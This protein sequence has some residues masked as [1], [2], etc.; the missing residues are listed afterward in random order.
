MAEET[1]QTREPRQRQRSSGAR[2]SAPRSSASRASAVRVARGRWIGVRASAAVVLVAAVIGLLFFLRPTTS[3][4]EKRTLKEFPPFTLS[5]FLSGEWTSEVAL[6]YS[7]TYPLREPMVAVSQAIDTLHGV[8]PKTQLIGSGTVADE[9]PPVSDETGES[10]EVAEPAQPTQPI[11]PPEEDDGPVEVPT[12]E[13]MQADIQAN[14]MS[15]LYVKDGAAYSVYYFVQSAVDRYAQAINACA[16][17]LAGEANVYC[18]LVPNNSGVMLDEDTLAALGGTDPAQA[19]KYFY[20]LMDSNVGKVKILEPLRAHNDEYLYFRTDHHWTQLGAYYAYLEFCKVSG[21]EPKPVL[22]WEKMSWDGFLGTF[23][24]QLGLADM[25][26][27]PDRVDAYIPTGTNEL[28][29]W[30]EVGNQTDWHV[31]TD[32]TGWDRSSYYATF[33]GGDRTLSKVVNPKVTDGSTCLVI[34]D[35]YG[36]AFVP[37]LIDNY[38][39]TYVIDYRYSNQNIP[40]FVREHGV[41]DVIYV[42]NMTLASTDS[43]ANKLYSMATQ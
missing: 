1:K 23:Y 8:E 25:A 28:T 40:Q 19:M 31:I 36:C 20:S 17:A 39:T 14:I 43:V 15:N 22:E 16:D 7:D 32:V 12:T 33:I 3:E 38:A 35:S 4:V 26:A 37:C 27:N 6:W 34:K 30:D 10:G 41:D 5:S 21:R 13:V 24:S 42:N 2:A 11:A 18:M 9:L 29:F